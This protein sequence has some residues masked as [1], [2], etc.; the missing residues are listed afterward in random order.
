[1]AKQGQNVWYDLTTSDPAG[2]MRFYAEIMGWKTQAWPDSD[3]NMPYTMWMV[4]NRPVGGVMKM[5]PDVNAPH[6]MSYTRVDD[7]DATAEQAKKLG[8]SVQIGPEDIPKVGRFAVLTDPQGAAFAVLKPLEDMPQVKPE[9]GDF[10]WS[11]LNTTDYESAWKFYSALFGW[12]H[13][14]SMDMGREMGI[15]F[16]FKDP[17]G[18]TKGGMSNVATMMKMP[19]HW[20]HYV[21]VDEV[22]AA[23][24]R[25]KSR[26]GEVLNGPMDVP[27][28]GQ[29]AQCVDPQGAFFA[30]HAEEK[31]KK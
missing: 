17:E 11:E 13:T 19:A 10:I 15:Y 6:W 7:V 29:I 8:G 31:G 28:G 5:P 16:M 25:V 9:V 23:V 30:I 22:A 2:A 12:Q 24:E 20:L 1:M 14:E 18:I 21:T 3:P 26:G 4:G 27:G